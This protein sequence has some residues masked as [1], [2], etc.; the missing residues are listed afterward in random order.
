[1]KPSKIDPLY[2][3]VV[4]QNALDEPVALV[5]HSLP[6]VTMVQ[7]A[8]LSDGAVQ[9]G[10]ALAPLTLGFHDAFLVGVGFSIL[11]VILSAAARDAR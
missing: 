3:D 11:A 4:S 5:F 9:G 7:L 2:Q 6:P 1:M 10:A 8:G